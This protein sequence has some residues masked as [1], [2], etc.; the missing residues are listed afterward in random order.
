MNPII[1]PV[2]VLALLALILPL[3]IRLASAAPSPPPTLPAEV[4]DRK[5]TPLVEHADKILQSRLEQH[6][7]SRKEWRRLISGRKMAVG[8]VDLSNPAAPRYANVNGEVEIYAASLP[9]IAILLA[10]FDQFEKG[11]LERTTDIDKDLNAMIRVSNNGAATRMIDKLGG[12]MSVNSVLRDPRYGFYSTHNGGG[13]WVGKRY[14]KQ[15]PRFPDPLNNISHAATV[16]QVCRF[17]YQLATGRLIN[18]TASREMLGILSES[19]I[20]HKFVKSLRER[21]PNAVLY[22]KSGTWKRWHADSV[23]VWGPDWRRYI[24][25]ALV[26]SPQGEPLHPGGI[27][28]EPPGRTDPA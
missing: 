23:L 8:L 2:G 24:L 15:G 12:L 19:A 11:S 3:T 28:G 14:A 5:W 4:P 6:L 27:G 7:N 16:S 22:R 18:P 9:K 26:E 13:L 21:D 1:R 20:E 10:A 25:V 17:Y